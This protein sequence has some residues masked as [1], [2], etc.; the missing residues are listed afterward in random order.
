I[1]GKLVPGMGGAMDLVNGVKKVII[2][3]EHTDKHGNSKV[4]KQCSLPLTGIKCVD[5]L[6]TELG[7]FCFDNGKMTLIELQ[8]N[9]TLDELKAK[10]EAT[11]ENGLRS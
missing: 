1:P 6:I 11:F 7:V 2:M 4:K 8:P 9:V 10:T 3:M 5:L